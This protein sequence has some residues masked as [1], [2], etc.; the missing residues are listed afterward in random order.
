MYF[1]LWLCRL[2]LLGR[3]RV[4]VFCDTAGTL[5]CLSVNLERPENKDDILFLLSFP[6]CKSNDEL[7]SYFL[8]SIALKDELFGKVCE[9]VDSTFNTGV[10]C[11]TLTISDLYG[12]P[13]SVGVNNWKIVFVQFSCSK[14]MTHPPNKTAWSA[15]LWGSTL[16]GC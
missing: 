7:S 2:A 8:S 10:D 1:G 14:T 5:P 11:I 3:E 15:L 4:A 12:N 9:V 13:N 16:N 6:S